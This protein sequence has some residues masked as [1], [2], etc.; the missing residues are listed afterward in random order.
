MVAAQ[1][2]LSP[3]ALERIELARAQRAQDRELKQ[4][5]AYHLAIRCLA[6]YA[7]KRMIKDEIRARG[8]RVSAFTARQLTE[9]AELY[10]AANKA[11]LI[12]DS[13]RAIDAWPEFARWRASA[14]LI[15]N[16]QT[17]TQPNSTT[18]AVQML[19]AK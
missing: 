15:T 1:R 16:A 17:Q 5:R 13:Q 7:A 19:G 9:L 12:H 4:R 8:L 11:Q 2:S 10:F 14:K 6:M 18:S 3:K